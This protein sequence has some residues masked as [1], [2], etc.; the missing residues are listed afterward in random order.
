[1]ERILPIIQEDIKG[2]MPSYLVGFRLHI[3]TIS[4]L[5]LGKTCYLLMRINVE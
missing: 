4:P 2:E 3:T 1:M 5:S